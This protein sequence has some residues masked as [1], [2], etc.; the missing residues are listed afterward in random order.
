MHTIGSPDPVVHPPVDRLATPS[1][2]DRSPTRLTTQPDRGP[3]LRHQ[4]VLTPH[5]HH[6]THHHQQQQDSQA[7]KLVKVKSVESRTGSTGNVTQVRTRRSTSS[8]RLSLGD[9][10][11]GMRVFDGM[12]QPFVPRGSIDRCTELLGGRSP[13]DHHTNHTGARGV[14]GRPQPLHPAERQGPRARGK[15]VAAN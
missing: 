6:N 7:V 4:P 2:I 3:P 1:V 11:A 8:R 14:P 9:G 15:R 13:R 10:V 5:H 12:L